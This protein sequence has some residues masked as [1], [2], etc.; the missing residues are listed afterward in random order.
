MRYHER[1]EIFERLE[2]LER[3]LHDRHGHGGHRR[4]HG[5]GCCDHHHHGDEGGCDFE[6]KRV[7]DTIV[8][9]VTEQV[10][11]LLAERADHRHDDDGGGEKRLIDTIVACVAEHVQEIVATELDRRLGRA[12]LP[13]TT[14]PDG[15]PPPGE[16]GKPAS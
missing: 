12:P 1:R 6:E 11:K 8:H 15:T 13:G 10:G 14:P 7:I 9:L 2:A 5:H 4:S 16:P 3:L